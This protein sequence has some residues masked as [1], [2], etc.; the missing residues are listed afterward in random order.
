MSPFRFRPNLLALSLS[1]RGDMASAFQ[2]SMDLSRE[3]VAPP[4]RPDRSRFVDLCKTSEFR[5]WEKRWE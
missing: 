4:N 1:R 2:E 5:S 3:R